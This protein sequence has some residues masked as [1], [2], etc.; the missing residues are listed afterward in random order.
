[1]I[2]QAG[3]QSICE[4]WIMELLEAV[5]KF[6]GI[7]AIKDRAL[8][9]VVSLDSL[10]MINLINGAGSTLLELGSFNSTS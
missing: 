5:E 1:M 4:Y 7:S 3:K 10:S 8:P 2:L 9:I 6:E